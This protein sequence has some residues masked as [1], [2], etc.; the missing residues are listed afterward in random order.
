MVDDVIA[1][2]DTRLTARVGIDA[3]HANRH[4]QS[5]ARA[6]SG[7]QHVTGAD[8]GATTSANALKDSDAQQN[9]V[10]ELADCSGLSV[11]DAIADLILLGDEERFAERLD[12]VHVFNLRLFAKR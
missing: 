12:Q 7:S 5:G 8:E 2:N 10:R 3:A 4:L 6:M 11:D 9:L 1:R